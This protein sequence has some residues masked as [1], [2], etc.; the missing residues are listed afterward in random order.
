MG[1]HALGMSPSP[2]VQAMLGGGSFDPLSLSPLFFSYYN[3]ITPTAPLTFDA[4]SSGSV[5]RNIRF[6]SAW[7]VACGAV[8]STA[9]A[10]YQGGTVELSGYVNPGNNLTT[11]ITGADSSEVYY[12]NPSAVAE[13][14]GAGNG[15]A[16]VKLSGY[17]GSYV[18]ARGY[19]FVPGAANTAPAVNTNTPV[20]RK[21]LG[22]AASYNRPIMCTSAALAGAL[23]GS[24]S[25]TLLTY[26]RPEQVNV[27]GVS[28]SW[29][30]FADASNLSR[31]E[32]RFGAATAASLTL[33]TGSSSSTISMT[34]SPGLTMGEYQLLAVTYSPNA[35]AM[36]I[37]GV[38]VASVTSAGIDRARANL[39]TVTMQSQGHRG[40]RALDAAF[41]RVLS[42]AELVKITKWCQANI[43]A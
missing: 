38:Q 5:S 15:T 11:T 10:S 19:S 35:A 31:V 34:M 30:R 33:H 29:M 43:A 20:G 23:N 9:S 27:S 37:D 14:V 28:T 26:I 7:R 4:S 13:T 39:S 6:S 21:V 32:A 41:D 12:A 24:T 25:L 17:A 2:N 36:H 18:D 16:V 1:G 40:F 42:S 3:T 8:W 22:W